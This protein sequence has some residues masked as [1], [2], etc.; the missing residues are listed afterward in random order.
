MNDD[1]IIELYWL[2]DEAAITE[3]STK[4]GAYCYTIAENILSC[5]E[6]SEECVSDT[7]LRAWDKMPPERPLRLGIFFGRIIRNLAIDRFRRRK[8]EKYGGGQTVICLD[9]LSECIGEESSV[10]SRVEL[11]EQLESFLRELPERNR[12]IFLLRYWYMM[13]VSEIAGRYSMSAGAVKMVLQRL[14]QKLKV[15]LEKE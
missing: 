9:E 12:Q 3:S 4:Y 8:A 7:W 6:D 5:R 14:R 15:H 10:E 1:R 2:R 13:P 11:K